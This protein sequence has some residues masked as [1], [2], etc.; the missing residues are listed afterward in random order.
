MIGNCKLS[1]CSAPAIASR[2]IGLAVM[3]VW[4]VGFAGCGDPNAAGS[5]KVYPVKGQVLRL[6]TKEPERVLEWTLQTAAE[7]RLP[8]QDVQI[9]RP[10]LESVF[11]S[12]TGREYR[13]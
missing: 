11:L 8:L 3:T 13:E 6:H 1:P 9:L 5:M 4:A 12:L 7:L 2:W 10:S